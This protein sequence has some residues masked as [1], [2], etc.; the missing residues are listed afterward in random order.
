MTPS[1]C[2]SRLRLGSITRTVDHLSLEDLS[3]EVILEFLNHLEEERGNGINTRNARLTAIHSFFRYVV[4][5]EPALAL[6]CQRI[7]SIPYK[8][9]SRRILGYLT[10][11]EIESLLGHVDRSAVRGERDYVL[12]ALLYDTGARIQELLNLKPV[13]LPP[14]R[15]PPSCG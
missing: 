2:F 4:T 10:E 11:E 7:L 12:L 9:T 5:S 6:L 1:R 14:G 13:C 15:L 8:K 3:V